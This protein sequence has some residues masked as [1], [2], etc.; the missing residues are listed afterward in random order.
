MFLGTPSAV[1][2]PQKSALARAARGKAAELGHDTGDL[3]LRLFERSDYF[4]AHFARRPAV[5]ARRA[6]EELLLV[7]N[8]AATV[9]CY[10]RE[11]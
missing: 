1:A 3:E 11:G 9:E 6:G 7:L 8:G 4:I 10:F 2:E 5:A